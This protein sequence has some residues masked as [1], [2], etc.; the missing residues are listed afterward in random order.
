MVGA[1]LAESNAQQIAAA[2][3][4]H[5]IVAGAVGERILRF[6]PPLVAGEA[7]VSR[8]TDTLDAVLGAA[9]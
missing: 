6:L 4:E 3:L 8:L 9:S 5:G 1:E 2:L 7:E